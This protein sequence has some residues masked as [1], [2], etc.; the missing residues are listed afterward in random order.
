MKK[1]LQLILLLIV[2]LNIP[3]CFTRDYDEDLLIYFVR[4]ISTK[5]YIYQISIYGGTPKLLLGDGVDSYNYPCPSPDDKISPLQKKYT[6][7]IYRISDMLY[8]EIL[9]I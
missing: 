8:T 9:Y 1:N 2:I 5:G 4:T 7:I 6:S 3:A